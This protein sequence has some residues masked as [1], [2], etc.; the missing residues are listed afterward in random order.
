M[1]FSYLKVKVKLDSKVAKLDTFYSNTNTAIFG[2]T[3]L[4]GMKYNCNI[5]YI[6][7]KHNIG[8]YSVIGN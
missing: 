3:Q 7:L 1:T 2:D 4:I 6:M 8:V 5:L